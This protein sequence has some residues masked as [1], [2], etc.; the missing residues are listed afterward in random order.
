[1]MRKI[2]F[3]FILISQFSIAQQVAVLE[4]GGG[5]DWYSDPTAVP[6]LVKFC[7]SNINT[8]IQEK[9]EQVKP[10]SP[11]IFQY[12]YIEMTGHGNV[13]FSDVE[14][15]NLK[16]YLLSG[17]FL[18]ADD[19]YGMKPYFIKAM[20]KVFPD[21][22][23]KELPS[24]HEIFNNVYSFPEG[25][26]KIHRHDNERPQALGLFHDGRLIVLFTT[27]SDISDG[28]DDASDHNDPEDVRLKALKMG[29]NI[30]H[31]VFTH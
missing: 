19:N 5:G 16:K 6:N 22:Q 3:L 27:E 2:L 30:L 10:D 13:S 25:L 12:A 18:H 7:N 29:A 21:K 24:D 9:V 14:A 4:Y 11:N 1:M 8:A 31:Y 20:K 26:P 28:W 17:G 23:W 15:K